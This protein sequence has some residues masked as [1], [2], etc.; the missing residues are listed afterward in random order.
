MSRIRRFFRVGVPV[1]VLT[2]LS[3]LGMQGQAMATL[4]PPGPVAVKPYTTAN[5]GLNRDV[6]EGTNCDPRIQEVDAV[7]NI[8][9]VGPGRVFLKDITIGFYGDRGG[10]AGVLRV[11]PKNGTEPALEL[12]PNG[13][14]VYP[15]TPPETHI[16]YPVN[17]WLNTDVIVKQGVNQEIYPGEQGIGCAAQ[18][19]FAAWQ[20][21]L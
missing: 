3:L 6:H 5:L 14:I 10:D 20:I 17:R 7:A 4:Y 21:T 11:E 13:N 19:T 8:G 16:T 2:A 12:R 9:G 18:N 1:V 15:V